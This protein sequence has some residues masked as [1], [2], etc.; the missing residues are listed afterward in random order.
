MSSLHGHRCPRC[1]C[2]LV[3]GTSSARLLGGQ[4][5]DVACG[6]RPH[7]AVDI[8]APRT[9]TAERVNPTLAGCEAGA[10]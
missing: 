6:C 9:G 2:V 1:T 7:R 8:P 5:R 4:C 10:G 3:V